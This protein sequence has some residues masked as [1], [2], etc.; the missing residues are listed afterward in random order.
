MPGRERL[1]KLKS[2]RVVH[3]STGGVRPRTPQPVDPVGNPPP[4]SSLNTVAHLPAAAPA[5]LLSRNVTGEVIPPAP[6]QKRT[7]EQKG[8]L[9]ISR[10]L[11]TGCRGHPCPRNVKNVK[12]MVGFTFNRVIYPSRRDC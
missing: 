1:R 9:D 5:G 12:P 11:L 10:F 3:K 7:S 2:R 6:S 4:T 8:V